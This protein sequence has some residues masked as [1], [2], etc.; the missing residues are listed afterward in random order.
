[1]HLERGT[2][3]K[4]LSRLLGHPKPSVTLDVYVHLLDGATAPRWTW[5]PSWSRG[6]TMGQRKPRIH[7]ATIS[8]PS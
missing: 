3:I 4:Q 2:N 7:P 5:T 8:M 1:M 6:A